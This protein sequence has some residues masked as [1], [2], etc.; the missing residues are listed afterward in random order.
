MRANTVKPF[1]FTAAS[2]LFI[3]SF[4]PWL[5]RIVVNPSTAIP[6]TPQKHTSAVNATIALLV[7]RGVDGPRD[8]ATAATTSASVIPS[9]IDQNSCAHWHNPRDMMRQG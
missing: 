8:F 4:G 2:S 5:L 7:N 6:C 3:V 9:P 1:A